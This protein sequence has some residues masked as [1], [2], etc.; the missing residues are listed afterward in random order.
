[1]A[2]YYVNDVL[3]MYIMLYNLLQVAA[4]GIESRIARMASAKTSLVHENETLSLSTDNLNWTGTW[5]YVVQEYNGSLSM[6]R[7]AISV[8]EFI[9]AG[10]DTYCHFVPTIAI[11]RLISMNPGYA[12]RTELVKVSNI[13]KLT[14]PYLLVL[15]YYYQI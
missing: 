9:R 2:C 11:D 10:E 8:L 4:Y 7:P 12:R 15:G 6:P 3:L 1:M 14:I 5:G 13:L